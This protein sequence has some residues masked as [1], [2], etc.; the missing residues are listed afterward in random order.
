M[1]LLRSLI[2]RPLRRDPANVGIM[3]GSFRETAGLWL[4]LQVRAD[5]YVRTTAR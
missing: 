5:L 4:D 3:A 2:L 1:K